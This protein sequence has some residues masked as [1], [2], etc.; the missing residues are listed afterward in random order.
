MALLAVCL[1]RRH[2][3]T[4]EIRTAE[5]QLLAA[6]GEKRSEINI[7]GDRAAFF[8]VLSPARAIE[9]R[10]VWREY[11]VPVLREANFHVYFILWRGSIPDTQ[12]ERDLHGDIL[13][14]ETEEGSSTML[15]ANRTLEM[16]SWALNQ[17]KP[18]FD[19]FIRSDLDTFWCAGKLRQSLNIHDS[20]PN[21]LRGTHWGQYNFQQVPGWSTPVSDVHAVY[22]RF[23]VSVFIKRMKVLWSFQGLRSSQETSNNSQYESA[24]QS[25]ASFGA[26]WA[27]LGDVWPYM[28]IAD[29]HV[30]IQEKNMSFLYS[31]EYHHL[32]R[33]VRTT[34][35]SFRL[36]FC[37]YC[38]AL[39][40]STENQMEELRL[41]A[42]AT[43]IK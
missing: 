35:K 6:C 7:E 10:N 15:Y 28:D 19:W 22:D 12:E 9:M 26:N 29:N 31:L 38:F 25:I 41:M 17:S 32:G 21:T 42:S 8:G 33:D 1:A 18:K 2:L 37:E 20:S 27:S 5:A 39:H 34:T 16:F 14:V 11:S 40:I 24:V 3:F 30:D 4:S 36:L 13:Y 23:A 43:P